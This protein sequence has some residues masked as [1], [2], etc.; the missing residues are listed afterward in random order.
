MSEECFSEI[1]RKELKKTRQ[2][3]SKLSFQSFK[4]LAFQTEE[5]TYREDVT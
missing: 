3:S 5:S 4:F 2:S 1:K